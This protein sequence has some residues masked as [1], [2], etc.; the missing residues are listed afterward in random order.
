MLG[1]KLIVDE[2]EEV[3]LVSRNQGAKFVIDK[4]QPINAVSTEQRLE[5]NLASKLSLKADDGLLQKRLVTKEQFLEVS[6]EGDWSKVRSFTLR[7]KDSTNKMCEGDS[8]KSKTD[9]KSYMSGFGTAPADLRRSYS[10]K[11]RQGRDSLPLMQEVRA[12]KDLHRS[13]PSFP[14]E[15]VDNA[16]KHKIAQ[17]E[18]FFHEDKKVF[19]NGIRVFR[20]TETELF[21]N[22]DFIVSL[23]RFSALCSKAAD[24]YFSLE[25]ISFW[26]LFS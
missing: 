12:R 1:R 16:W 26:V 20:V 18:L 15:S 25:F 2:D 3:N 23:Y 6:P 11:C 19:A 21:F 14:L 9:W 22:K 7:S 8:F 5:V 24:P 13:R 17:S 10:E 4:V